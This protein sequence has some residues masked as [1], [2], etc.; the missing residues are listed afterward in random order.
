MK[1][2]ISLEAILKI[3][4]LCCTLLAVCS[5][6][7][8]HD[9]LGMS[10]RLSVRLIP[11]I[12]IREQRLPSGWSSLAPTTDQRMGVLLGISQRIKD[13]HGVFAYTP[14]RNRSC[15]NGR[16]PVHAGCG[17]RSFR[18]GYG[19]GSFIGY[20]SSFSHDRN[21]QAR[22]IT[23]SHLMITAFLPK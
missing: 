2:G 4:P 1:Q 7:E 19:G 16:Y 14:E 15:R 17:R 3:I 22:D 21:K 20:R 23:A 10:I 12:L 6:S 8:P 13:H 5:P 18:P 9:P 11:V